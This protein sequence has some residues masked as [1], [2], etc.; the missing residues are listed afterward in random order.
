[1]ASYKYARAVNPRDSVARAAMGEVGQGDETCGGL[2]GARPQSV[3]GKL[4]TRSHNSSAKLRV[5]GKQEGSRGIVF[6]A[7]R[8]FQCTEGE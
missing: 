3:E 1:M 6:S 7:R 4:K 2:M 8:C 5:C